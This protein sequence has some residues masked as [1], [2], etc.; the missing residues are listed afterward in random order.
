MMQEIHF[1]LMQRIREKRDEMIVSDMHI[2]PRIKKQLDIYVKQ[3]KEWRASWEGATRYLVK[4]GTKAVTVD[5]DKK[6]LTVGSLILKAYHVH[7]QL[8]PYMVERCI[9]VTLSLNILRETCILP[10]TVTTLRLSKGRATRK[11]TV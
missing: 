6:S 3:S 4:S 8:L 5:L 9:Q 11:S 2:Y 1:K 7:M 10:P